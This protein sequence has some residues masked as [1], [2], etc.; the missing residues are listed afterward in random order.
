MLM[1]QPEPATSGLPLPL[2]PDSF[3]PDMPR[4]IPSGPFDVAT[5]SPSSAPTVSRMSDHAPRLSGEPDHGDDV[6]APL[7]ARLAD[8]TLTPRELGSTGEEY[9]ARWLESRGWTVME[10]N[11]RSRYGELDLVALSPERRLVFVEVKTRRTMRQ[12]TPQEAVTAA[13]RTSLRR[14]GVQWLMEPEHR[15]AHT[16]VRFDVLAVSVHGSRP[17]VH[18]IPEAF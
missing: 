10:R 11:W 17:F 8:P 7:G 14:A 16:G 6:L 15:I 13:K 4:G 2:S 12:G 3:S 9:A 5:E 1:G 18:H